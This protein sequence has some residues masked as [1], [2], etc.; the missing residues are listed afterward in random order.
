MTLWLDVEDLFHH[1]SHNP[2]PSGIQRLSFEIYAEL[3]ALL[4]EG[5]RFCRH[6]PVA[7]TLRTVPWGVLHALFGSLLVAAAHTE[8]PATVDAPPG[9][10]E[11]GRLRRMVRRLP[12]EIR[13]PLAQAL[14]AQRQALLAQR[15]VLHQ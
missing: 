1:A 5:V 3:H 8:V 9:P 14:A 12:L 10:P 11:P 4:G 15:N 7:G 13:D 6:D 2:R